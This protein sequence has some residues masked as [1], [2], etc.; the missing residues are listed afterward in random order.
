MQNAAASV[1]PSTVVQKYVNDGTNKE[2]GVSVTFFR[3]GPRSYCT[4]STATGQYLFRDEG[5][6][7]AAFACTVRL[8]ATRRM[9]VAGGA[10]AASMDDSLLVQYSGV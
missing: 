1:L 4:N 7:A 2:S 10:V 9:V 8:A 6:S 3:M 5:N